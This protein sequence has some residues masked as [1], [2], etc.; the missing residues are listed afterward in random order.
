MS[1]VIIDKDSPSKTF[2]IEPASGKAQRAR[3]RAVGKQ[4]IKSCARRWRRTTAWWG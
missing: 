1:K 2:W 4:M 3:Q